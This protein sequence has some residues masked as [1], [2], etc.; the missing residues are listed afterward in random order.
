MIALSLF[1]SLNLNIQPALPANEDYTEKISFKST[2]LPLRQPI[3]RTPIV[4]VISLI[5]LL[6][7]K[8][9]KQLPQLVVFGL[10]LK[11][12]ISNDSQVFFKLFRTTLTKLVNRHLLLN[13]TNLLVFVVLVVTLMT[14]P[15]KTTPQTIK[16]H[17]T[18]TL[19]IVT[20]SLLLT[21]MSMNRS[22]SRSPSQTLPL[23]VGNVLTVLQNK[24]LGQPE[25]QQVQLML[26]LTNADAEVVRLNVPVQKVTLVEVLDQRNHL[27][28]EQKN[29]LQTKSFVVF[30]QQGLQRVPHQIHHEV[31]EIILHP[32]TDSLGYP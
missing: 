18:D 9:T 10:L 12:K 5:P 11:T 4:L 24:R 17:I 22:V 3:R 30:A 7:K 2:R 6:H 13:L 25:V 21:V 15:R 27:I 32:T 8:V 26:V 14:L 20:T 1:L 29:R 28:N 23:L 31:V 19:H 16:R